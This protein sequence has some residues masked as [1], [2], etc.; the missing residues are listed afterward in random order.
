MAKEFIITEGDIDRELDLLLEVSRKK[1]QKFADDLKRAKAD[2]RGLKRFF[3]DNVGYRAI[4]PDGEMKDFHQLQFDNDLVKSKGA[5]E[6]W[7]KGEKRYPCPEEAPPEE[8]CTGG[9]VK[10]DEGECRCPPGY[11][12]EPAKELSEVEGDVIPDGAEGKCVKDEEKP[13]KRLESTIKIYDWSSS[14]GGVTVIGGPKYKGDL[15]KDEWARIFGPQTSAFLEMYLSRIFADA[16]L[17][18]GGGM[19]IKKDGDDIQTVML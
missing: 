3:G 2:G 5:A 7:V 1:R 18:R 6:C 14:K 11:R 13:A 10:N 19:A 17:K 8:G 12:W 9:R 15:P 4:N 16:I